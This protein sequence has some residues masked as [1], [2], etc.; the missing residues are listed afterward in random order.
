MRLAG[1]VFVLLGAACGGTGAATCAPPA[2][3][4]CGCPGSPAVV[5]PVCTNG[6][7]VC[8]CQAPVEAG[9]RDAARDVSLD[10]GRPDSASDAPAASDASSKEGTADLGAVS[11]GGDRARCLGSGGTVVTDLCCAG[12]SDFP[13]LC[14]IGAC[15]CAPSCSHDVMSCSC[16]GSKCFQ[17]GVGCR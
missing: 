3:F 4:Q 12:V 8:H 1:V 15:S 2:P 6:S 5:S 17:A 7:W 16:P 14:S 13:D 10:S 11:D 9:P